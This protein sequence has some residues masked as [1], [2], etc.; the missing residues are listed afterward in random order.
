MHHFESLLHEAIS[1]IFIDSSQT[2]KD[3]FS[4]EEVIAYC[5]SD[6]DVQM[7]TNS[8]HFESKLI[9]N[10]RQLDFVALRGFIIHWVNLLKKVFQFTSDSHGNDVKNTAFGKLI[11]LAVS[12]LA[13]K[14]VET[15]IINLISFSKVKSPHNNIIQLVPELT[16]SLPSRSKVPP[17]PTRHPSQSKVMSNA[18]HLKSAIVS[19]KQKSTATSLVVFKSSSQIIIQHSLTIQVSKFLEFISS[20]FDSLSVNLLQ[21]HMGCEVNEFDSLK[22]LNEE[23]YRLLTNYCHLWSQ[24]EIIL[25]SKEAILEIISSFS[26]EIASS[27][28]SINSDERD[29]RT[30]I[31]KY[32]WNSNTLLDN[33]RP[34]SVTSYILYMSQ[35]KLLIEKLLKYV[36]QLRHLDQNLCHYL[37]LLQT[38]LSIASES[39]GISSSVNFSGFS[40]GSE[41]ILLGDFSTVNIQIKG[42]I[43][44][45]AS[46]WNSKSS[47]CV[48]PK[49]LIQE[50]KK[51]KFDVYLR[52]FDHSTNIFNTRCLTPSGSEI[53]SEKELVQY[54]NMLNSLNSTNLSAVE[55]QKVRNEH[56]RMNVPIEKHCFLYSYWLVQKQINITNLTM[57]LTDVMK[58]I[59]LKLDDVSLIGINEQSTKLVTAVQLPLSGEFSRNISKIDIESIL[60]N[61]HHDLFIARPQQVM[62]SYNSLLSL[63][64]C[65]LIDLT[66]SIA[67]FDLLMLKN[68]VN[69]E[70]DE[71]DVPV[72]T[73]FLNT[74]LSTDISQR[75][76]HVSIYFK[77]IIQEMELVSNLCSILTSK[78]NDRIIFFG[79]SCQCISANNRKFRSSKFWAAVSTQ[80]CEVCSNFNFRHTI[81]KNI[82]SSLNHSS[83]VSDLCDQLSYFL[84]FTNES[85]DTSAMYFYVS[86]IQSNSVGLNFIQL[87]NYLAAYSPRYCHLITYVY[88]SLCICYQQLLEKLASRI[89]SQFHFP[90]SIS[91][92]VNADAFALKKKMCNE[93]TYVEYKHIIGLSYRTRSESYKLCYTRKYSR[94]INKLS[95]DIRITHSVLSNLP[96]VYYPVAK[97]DVSTYPPDI[98]CDY[99]DASTSLQ[100]EMKNWS[101]FDFEIYDEMNKILQ[102]SLSECSCRV[103]VSSYFIHSYLD[104]NN[105]KYK[106]I[107]LELIEFVDK[108]LIEVM[109]WFLNCTNIM[110]TEN[111]TRLHDALVQYDEI[112]ETNI[113]FDLLPA[114]QKLYGLASVVSDHSVSISDIDEVLCMNDVSLQGSLFNLYNSIRSGD[115]CVIKSE[116]EIRL[117]PIFFNFIDDSRIKEVL[118]NAMKCKYQSNELVQRINLLTFIY[119]LKL[120][121][122]H[123]FWF[124]DSK[125]EMQ[126][127]YEFIYNECGQDIRKTTGSDVK[128]AVPNISV[129]DLIQFYNNLLFNS[130]KSTNENINMIFRNKNIA[131]VRIDFLLLPQIITSEIQLVERE[132][133]NQQIEVKLIEIIKT[134]KEYLSD[135]RNISVLM[136]LDTL[137]NMLQTALSLKHHCHRNLILYNVVLNIIKL[138]KSLRCGNWNVVYSLLNEM[139]LSD[140]YYTNIPDIVDEIRVITKLWEDNNLMHK[141]FIDSMNNNQV[142]GTC[143]SLDTSNVDI[144]YLL[145][146]LSITKSTKAPIIS[147][148][149]DSMVYSVEKLIKVRKYLMMSDYDLLKFE[150]DGIKL[151]S[152]SC[153]CIDEILLIKSSLDVWNNLNC[154]YDSLT[155]GGISGIVGTIDISCKSLS[156]LNYSLLAIISNASQMHKVEA[157]EIIDKHMSHQ[158]FNYLKNDFISDNVNI[159]STFPI[160]IQYFLS[161][162]I[163]IEKLRSFVKAGKWNVENISNSLVFFA[164][165]LEQEMHQN[166]SYQSC[167]VENIDYCNELF[168][169]ALSYSKPS[170][171]Y[172]LNTISNSNG[173]VEVKKFEN[174]DVHQAA[175]HIR[176]QHKFAESHPHILNNEFYLKKLSLSSANIDSIINNSVAKDICKNSTFQRNTVFF[177]KAVTCN[178]NFNSFTGRTMTNFETSNTATDIGDIA[179]LLLSQV[180]IL[181]D[182]ADEV[183]LVRNELYNRISMFVMLKGLELNEIRFNEYYT[184]IIINNH[185]AKV[186]GHDSSVNFDL[187]IC[188][189][190]VEHL[191]IY[192]MSIFAL[193][194]YLTCLVIQKLRATISH[195][196]SIINSRNGDGVDDSTNSRV[197]SILFDIFSDIRHLKLHDAF[198]PIVSTELNRVFKFLINLNFRSSV[199]SEF[200]SRFSSVIQTTNI[201]KT[202]LELRYCLLRTVR[203]FQNTHLSLSKPSFNANG[204]SPIKSLYYMSSLISNSFNEVSLNITGNY[205]HLTQHSLHLLRFCIV[206]ID[207]LDIVSR[208]IYSRPADTSTGNTSPYSNKLMN[209]SVRRSQRHISFL[210]ND[211][212]LFIDSQ[213]DTSI[214]IFI[215][216]ELVQLFQSFIAVWNDLKHLEQYQCHRNSQ[217]LDEK[218]NFQ[219][220]N[221]VGCLADFVKFCVKLPFSPDYQL[222]SKSNADLFMSQLSDL[223]ASIM[224]EQDRDDDNTVSADECY[225]DEYINK[226][227]VEY[228]SVKLKQNDEASIIEMHRSVDESKIES[229][230]I[231][232]NSD[233]VIF[234]QDDVTKRVV[235]QK[236]DESTKSVLNNSYI[237]AYILQ[238]NQLSESL[239]VV[240]IPISCVCFHI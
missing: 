218:F 163:F 168:T 61:S 233:T 107:S 40:G 155:S 106:L 222:S 229:P 26:K 154:L 210:D 29:F 136:D 239:E 187:S 2:T 78:M 19:S 225:I 133:L 162:A 30:D 5:Q 3:L 63:F 152:I 38:P 52:E 206:S 104:L 164:S 214:S 58:D 68:F 34:S 209:N 50:L 146:S 215:T 31:S 118:H 17:P 235:A 180:S 90:D 91:I 6:E 130:E 102:F 25:P 92:N 137:D 189:R 24:F 173:N 116:L 76:P 232:F 125:Y 127:L 70:S 151:E 145:R 74:V 65:K 13:Y 149:D 21:T 22:Q 205:I 120:S 56:M 142:K 53:S 54:L 109:N 124:S 200:S 186:G 110:Y 33:D 165:T 4:M 18:T 179:D 47:P 66:S 182:I 71:S 190:V 93:R 87:L 86:F 45:I 85:C 183:I 224:L 95:R 32:L 193:K 77:K 44:T 204:N 223:Y 199:Y 114:S 122:N 194:R 161:N 126:E 184:D 39:S 237:A 88:T 171:E 191:G 131:L 117:K 228:N 132:L 185:N 234:V 60:Q 219:Y 59:I 176:I 156:D 73:R 195:Y 177:S 8:K 28:V 220:Q 207:F 99:K 197:M 139:K 238:I 12:R 123:G 94:G 143:W 213:T 55:H 75:F 135:L 170:S 134:G 147:K 96:K 108:L 121:S 119:Q 192:N 48:V 57:N 79:N 240:Y 112:R 230:K 20:S 10:I 41:N 221:G 37:S 140:N 201:K 36:E 9:E 188:L 23:L 157:N 208:L 62:N 27:N 159:P 103:E 158:N 64:E 144:I 236:T 115:N 1:G 101:W 113:L 43:N 153:H 172:S 42:R 148:N 169:N 14:R 167:Y 82:D 69:T 105:L 227:I 217:L 129:T 81:Q 166:T 16:F 72:V 7:W 100:L 35:I 150:L 178:S 46:E 83:I 212:S 174:V 231:S 226:C 11:E 138:R 15:Q 111:Q 196:L 128:Y 49:N 51:N 198:D 141:R 97:V 89:L 181:A 211:K 216:D 203:S 67:Y 84:L 175:K 160:K 98:F 80:V 202:L